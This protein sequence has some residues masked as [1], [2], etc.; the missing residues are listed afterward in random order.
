MIRPDAM[1]SAIRSPGAISPCVKGGRFRPRSQGVRLRLVATVTATAL[2]A[3]CGGGG[4]GGAGIPAQPAPP[5]PSSE[6]PSPPP[7]AP[8][9]APPPAPEA[10][11]PEPIFFL[12]SDTNPGN[13]T[14]ELYRALDNGTDVRRLSDQFVDLG[15]RVLNF[16]VSPDGQYVAYIATTRSN[17]GPRLFVV[18]SDS[19]TPVAVSP[20]LTPDPGKIYPSVYS[21]DWSPD[22]DRLVLAGNLSDPSVQAQEVFL[23]NIDGTGFE[24]IS[25][26]IRNP[27]VVEV[28]NPQ[29]SADGRYILQEVADFELRY[30][31]SKA[32]NSGGARFPHALNVHEVGGAPRNSVRLITTGAIEHVALSPNSNLVCI[33]GTKDRATEIYLSDLSSGAA[34]DRQLS[35]AELATDELCRWSRDGSKVAF[36]E[37]RRLNELTDLVTV[38]VIDGQD[39]GTP[40]LVHRAGHSIRDFSF[41]PTSNDLAILQKST[42]DGPQEIW[43][44]SGGGSLRVSGPLASGET[45]DRFRW[46]ANGEQIAYLKETAVGFFDLMTVGGLNVSAISGTLSARDFTWSADSDTLGFT[47]ASTADGEMADGLFAIELENEARSSVTGA[48]FREF[49]DAAYTEKGDGGVPIGLIVGQ[50]IAPTP[51]PVSTDRPTAVTI[52][53]I[54]VL[55]FSELNWE[56][57]HWDSG[58]ATTRKPDIRVGIANANCGALGSNFVSEV[59]RNADYTGTYSFEKGTEDGPGTSLP[60]SYKFEDFCMDINLRDSDV[61][62]FDFTGFEAGA[63]YIAGFRYDPAEHWREGETTAVVRVNADRGTQFRLN[64]TYSY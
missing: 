63:D 51:P 34:N 53:S 42:A 17:R 57:R 28:R 40:S 38:S 7:A 41:G 62:D 31:D 19:G 54:E 18:P 32:T 45:I 59:V 39:P 5:P 55:G 22:S 50:P 15:S 30:F 25:G 27:A 46:S 4:G 58:N 16:Q 6:T 10:G 9:P 35:S 11:S 24:K 47:A 14:V 26:G 61:G 8:A 64:V 56:G 44:T 37:G 29:W 3:A 36:V 60:L 2:L 48:N 23:V 12:A 33:A 1:P 13:G 20:D 49:K 52:N 43:R 21:F